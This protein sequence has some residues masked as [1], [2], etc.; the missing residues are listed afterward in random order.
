TGGSTGTWLIDPNDY[1]I[2]ASGGDA[3]GEEVSGWLNTSNVTISTATMGHS[4]GNGDIFVN[5]ALSW[6]TANTLT[7]RAERNINISA[8]ITATSGG[9]NLGAGT[10][11]FITDTAGINVG[12]YTLA[13]GT[14][15]QV[16]PTL[17]SFVANDFR[18]TGGTFI[19]AQGG[20]GSAGNAYEIADIYGLQGIAS[21]GMQD[22]NYQLAANIDATSTSAWNSRAGFAPI[23]YYISSK[24]NRMFTGTFDGLGH[25][26]TGLTMKRTSPSSLG[27][28][29]YTGGGAKISNV[30]LDSIHITGLDYLGGLVGYN[31]GTITNC[32]VIGSSFVYST[33]DSSGYYGNT[34]YSGGL[35]GHNTGTI[36]DC[37][38]TGTSVTGKYYVGGFVGDNT[39]TISNCAVTDLSVTGS[40]YV[41]GFVGDNTRTGKITNCS[42]TGKSVNGHDDVGGLVG[43]NEGTIRDSFSTDISVKGNFALGGLVGVNVGTIT[44]SH[45]DIDHVSIQDTNG[46]VSPGGVY[47]DQYQDWIDNGKTLEIGK[48]FTNISG[49][50]YYLLSSPNDLKNLLGFADL[51]GLKFR[52]TNDID[53]T[54]YPNLHIPYFAGLEFDGAGKVVSN[55]SIPDSHNYSTGFFDKVSNANIHDLN[56]RNVNVKGYYFVGGLVGENDHGTMTNCSSSGIVSG[57]EYMVGG[58]VGRNNGTIS[59]CYS[60]STVNGDGFVGGLVGWNAGGI[61]NCYSTGSLKGNYYFGGLVGYNDFGTVTNSY[62]DKETSGQS[63]SSGGTG[64]TTAEMMTKAKFTDWDFTS[65]GTWFMIE[66]ETRPFLRSEWSTTI[67]N[68]HQLQLMSMNPGA[69][70]RLGGNID[71]S[72]LGLAAGMWSGRG[73]VPV[74]DASAQFTGTFDGMGYTI[75]GLTFNRAVSSASVGLFSVTGIGANISNLFLKDVRATIGGTGIMFGGLVGINQGTITN[76]RIDIIAAE[77]DTSANTG[78]FGGLVGINFSNGMITNCSSSGNLSWEKGAGGLVGLNEGSVSNSYSSCSVDGNTSGGLVVVNTGFIGNSY[79][80]GTVSGST[81]GG[82]VGDNRGSITS[83]FSTGLVNNGVNGSEVGG[84]AGKNTGTIEKSYWDKEVSR[85]EVGVGDG[86]GIGVD[87]LTTAEMK[88]KNNFV[89]WDMADT[90]GSNAVWRIYEGETYPLLRSFLTP[91]TITANNPVKTYDGQPYTYGVADGVPSYPTSDAHLFGELVCTY[92]HQDKVHAGSYPNAITLSGLYSDQQGYDIIYAGGTLTIDPRLLTVGLNN[93]NV[94]KVYDG[95]DGAPSDFSP[96]WSLTGFLAGDTSADLK[97]GSAKYNSSHVGEANTLT[98]SGVEIIGVTGTNG[99]LSSDYQLVTIGNEPVTTIGTGATISPKA[100]ALVA[101]KG[102]DGSTGLTGHVVFSNLVGEEDLRYSDATSNDPHVLTG[103]YVKSITLADGDRGFASDYA[104]PDLTAASEANRVTINPRE[105]GLV[106]EKEYDG[107]TGLTGHVVFRNLVGEED[108]RY[109]DAT[110]NDPHVLT[111]RYVKTITL[112]DGDRGVASDYRLPA[113]DTASDANMVT[114]NPREVGLVA[115][116]GYDGTTGLTGHVV[117]RNLVGEEDLRYTD[118]MSNDSHVLTGRY[119]KTIT[120]ADG[121]RGFASDYALPDLTAASDANMVTINPREVGLVAEKEYDGSTGLTGHVV[122][123]NLVGEEDLRYTDATS[124]DSH[125]LTGRYVKTIT[126]ADGASGLASDYKL[127]ALDSASESNR[128]TISPRE[129]GLVAEKEYDGSTDLAG[130]VVFKNLVGEEDLRYSDATSN[131]PHVLTGRYVKTITLADGDRGF[132][133]DYKL[134]ALDAASEANAVTISQRMVGLV[135]EK[136]Y[137]GSTGLTGHVVFKNLVGE[138]DLRYTDATSNDPHVLTGRYVK[139]ITL[140]DGDRGFASDYALPDLT[141]ASEANRVTINP[142][143]VGLV[144]EKEY[145]GSTGLTGHVVFRNLVGEEDLRYTDATSNDSHVLTGRYVKTITLADGD[146]GVASDYRLPD[147]TA[148]TVNNTVTINPKVIHLDGS[149]YY[150]GNTRFV[151]SDFGDHGV[152]DGIGSEKLILTGTGTVASRTDLDVRQAL[153]IGDLRLTDGHNGGMGSDYTLAGGTHSGTIKS[154][155]FPDVAN[156]TRQVDGRMMS[157]LLFINTAFESRRGYVLSTEPPPPVVA[158]AGYTAPNDDEQ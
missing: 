27:L 26:I 103:R 143:E 96:I 47:H 1:T 124:N 116:K 35:V 155:E 54:G 41:G 57:S 60:T 51:S 111:G 43:G 23:G 131:D 108:L 76:C 13:S 120:L 8:D 95:N 101:E 93:M 102:Y 89:G 134:P 135:A 59:N 9:L 128:V 141:A 58:L 147:L 62:W 132:A 110:S 66:G 12:I 158:M 10:T 157:E 129:V 14:W 38:I 53:L 118:A 126:L 144:A 153:S 45:Y 142:R 77:N 30:V 71:M 107:S 5:D 70:Y 86:S 78:H 119:V 72:E 84:F 20:D 150:D 146:R 138:E 130:H 33:L 44:N 122:F 24:N 29:G 114:I 80:T 140:A 75:T 18:I 112:A 94:T 100:L 15:N 73:F 48:Y 88:K 3:T 148:A 16:G 6:T 121:D 91:L 31:S 97:Y 19:R 145:D 123:R 137:D 85:M 113:L 49:D 154:I 63:S 34:V 87:G 139:T 39:G 2:A 40:D 98:L 4:G 64:L 7:L 67:T 37:S 56:L 21:S 61:T 79:S 68:A 152:V 92:G 106:A 28:F 11:G 115:E 17:P 127:P 32:A 156:M 22:K 74:G 82:F 104:L 55:L 69:S 42:V 65:N 136:E 46:V 105:V 125:V 52:L 36:S 90:G 99:S 25:T 149:K 81:A 117:F 109:S 50:G 133:S 83:S 151:A